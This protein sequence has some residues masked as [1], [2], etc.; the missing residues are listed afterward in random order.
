MPKIPMKRVSAVTQIY[1]GVEQYA[2][3]D[4]NDQKVSL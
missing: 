4:A 2:K 3:N 1:F